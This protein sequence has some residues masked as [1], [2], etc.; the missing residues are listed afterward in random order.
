MIYLVKC[1]F[2]KR[3]NSLLW[4]QFPRTHH[5]HI[6]TGILLYNYVDVNMSLFLRLLTSG[7]LVCEEL[8]SC[9][10]FDLFYNT[11]VY[12]LLSYCYFF[13]NLRLTSSKLQ[14]ACALK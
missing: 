6:V 12:L 4:E 14:S 3:F 2:T 9:I 7:K 1:P 10:Q 8:S 11:V 13:C 5:A